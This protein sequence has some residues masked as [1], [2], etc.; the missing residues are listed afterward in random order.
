[1]DEITAEQLRQAA[2]R[3]KDMQSRSSNPPNGSAVPPVPD[4]VRLQNSGHPGRNN[5]ARQNS[6][7]VTPQPDHTPSPETAPPPVPQEGSAGGGVAKL[8]RMLNFKGLEADA[9]TGLILGIIFLL[10]SSGADELLT[11]ALIYI[12]L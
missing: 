2:Q 10:A 5:T 7:P 6:A 9:D 11:M 1:M 8:L 12:M 3:L 4:F